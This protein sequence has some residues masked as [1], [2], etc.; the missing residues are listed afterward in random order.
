MPQPLFRLMVLG[1]GLVALATG[2]QAQALAPFDQ[3]FLRSE[4]RSSAYELA[5]AR[6]A[7]RQAARRG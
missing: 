6:L 5:I 4:A 7:S 2:A 3:L 1:F